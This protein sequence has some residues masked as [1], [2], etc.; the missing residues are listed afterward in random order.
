MAVSVVAFLMMQQVVNFVPVAAP[1]TAGDLTARYHA[2]CPPMA[3][4]T[5]DALL[6]RESALVRAASWGDR[7]DST[8]SLVA[9]NRAI[10]STTGATGR[11]EPLMPA[12]ASWAQGAINAALQALA[13]HPTDTVAASL[14]AVVALAQNDPSPFRQ[15]HQALWKAIQR[16]VTSAP[17]LRACSEFALR[18][19]DPQA[20]VQCAARGLASG[21]DSTWH[22]MR[23][24]RERFRAADTLAGVLDFDAAVGAAHDFEARAEVEW[25]VQWF[26]SPAELQ[27][28]RQ[29][30][31]GVRPM[32]L[33]DRLAARDVRDG[34]PPGSRLAE[35]FQRLD[36]V[37]RHFRLALSQVVRDQ[38]GLSGVSPE[39]RLSP[40]LVLASPEPAVVPAYPVRFYRRWQPDIDDRGVVWMRFG[41]PTARIQM[42]PHVTPAGGQGETDSSNVREAWRYVVDGD[43]L[44]VNF[45]G[46]NFDGSGEATRL[47]AGVLGSYFCGFDARRCELTDR[48]RRN[49]AA[50]V[51]PTSASA[52]ASREALED[53][54][55]ADLRAIVR[56]TTEDDNTVRGRSNIRTVASLH[57]LWDPTT[58]AP[59]AL[60]TWAVRPGDLAV[61]RSPD[62]TTPMV[63]LSLRLRQWDP[64]R[65]RWRDT[66]VDRQWRASAA[67]GRE[68]LTGFLI[69]PSSRSVTTWSLF[70]SQDSTRLGR[71][72]ADRQPPIPTG[73]VVLSDLVIGSEAQGLAWSL[74]TS[75]VILAPQDTLDRAS[76]ASLYFQVISDAPRPAVRSSIA[77]TRSGGGVPGGEPVYQVTQ[78]ERMERGI[79][80]GFRDLDL[81]R[82]DPGPYR[83][84]LTLS[85]GDLPTPVV[86][87]TDLYLR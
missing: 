9:C 57:R 70:A 48:A 22:L 60:V 24:A 34:R 37:E 12:G 75:A 27:E 41:E 85:G 23:L 15:I 42:W 65:N 31:D 87:T 46:E 21:A 82:L 56:A 45:E 68:W 4:L 2:V 30:T 83:L 58:G 73:P 61:T 3:P 50:T 77:I 62:D 25:Q 54:R 29:L 18:L 28:W 1:G 36:H 51:S 52:A 6:D 66:S 10:L 11:E 84:Q 33:H 69:A 53:V 20:T 71:A 79:N 7:P 26:L 74:P 80:Q 67:M 40:D 8:W 78:E 43:S 35:H 39:N 19:G 63:R 81:S 64:G 38:G 72:W 13:D 86:R 16:G 44:L 49:A 17:V 14:L 59:I 47:V 32:W 55:N 76:P 5:R